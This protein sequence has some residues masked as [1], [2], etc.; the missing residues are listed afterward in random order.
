MGEVHAVEVTTDPFDQSSNH[1]DVVVTPQQVVDPDAAAPA[2]AGEFTLPE[3]F[4]SVED[5][6]RS[7]EEAQRKISELTAG[8]APAPTTADP[9]DLG[10]PDPQEVQPS[11][12]DLP[13][14]LKPYSDEYAKTGAL[15][16]ES[17]KAIHEQIGIPENLV[18]AFV[19]GARRRDASRAEE[20]M[21]VAGGPERYQEMMRWAAANT[22]KAERDN[23]LALVNG[24]DA[25]AAKLVVEG[26]H[27]RFTKSAVGHPGNL[28]G[29]TGPSDHR[30]FASFDEKVDAMADPRYETDS[31][32][33]RQ[34]LERIRL[35]DF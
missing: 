21:S 31:A 19:D 11:V 24:P 7:Y 26:L 22:D 6:H 32:Y 35:S 4:K 18:E 30:G 3:K 23:Y 14:L 9:G 33:T 16:Q 13:S 10:I 8:Q 17:V 34:V 15:S 5:L 12:Q 28:E 29:R 1:D 27:A 20:L 2:P 25:N